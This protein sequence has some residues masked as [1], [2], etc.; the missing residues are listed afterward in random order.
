MNT[1]SDEWETLV[2][3]SER[4][5]LSIESVSREI[6]YAFAHDEIVQNLNASS[7]N[8]EFRRKQK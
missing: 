5:G 3:I 2:E 6:S 8:P 1:F 4:T 7:G